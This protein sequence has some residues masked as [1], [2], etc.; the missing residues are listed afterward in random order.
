MRRTL[1][2]ALTLLVLMGTGASAQ[3]HPDTIV[4]RIEGLAGG[5]TRI[6]GTIR[7]RDGEEER[8]YTDIATPFEIRLPAQPLEASFGGPVGL[9]LSGEMTLLRDGKQVGWVSGTSR[10]GRLR[11]YRA[12]TGAYGFGSPV[13]LRSARF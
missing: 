11:F 5:P 10:I 1:G 12:G 3:D 9:R 7:L 4:L 6:S 2:A 13:A 8:R